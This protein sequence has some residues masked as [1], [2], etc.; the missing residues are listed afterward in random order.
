MRVAKFLTLAVLISLT[1]CSHSQAFLV[2]A[3]SVNAMGE[4][5][6]IVHD[7]ME[8]AEKNGLVEPK[9]Y[10]EWRTFGIKF[11]AA[12]PVA[13]DLLKIAILAD[14]LAMKEK[15]ANVIIDMLPEL[16]KFAELTGLTITEL[17]Q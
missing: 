11:Q 1:A 10:A 2:T 15:A 4:Q 3:Q 6:V 13:V 8:E 16:L 7:F 14:D 12:F 5:F 9:T 17:K